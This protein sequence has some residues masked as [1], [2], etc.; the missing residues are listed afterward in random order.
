MS[1]TGLLTDDDLIFLLGTIAW[2][3]DCDLGD[4][5]DS[6]VMAGDGVDDLDRLLAQ[7]DRYPRHRMIVNVGAIYPNY[8]RANRQ[9]IVNLR[10]KYVELHGETNEPPWPGDYTGA[11][12]MK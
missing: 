2:K 11:A 6:V 4:N 7:I 8:K 3:F 10:A 1:D 12:S 5:S 9:D